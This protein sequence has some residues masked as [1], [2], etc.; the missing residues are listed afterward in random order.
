MDD[1][2]D[3]CLATT[4]GNDIRKGG[5]GAVGVF[6]EK[7]MGDGRKDEEGSGAVVCNQSCQREKQ[8]TGDVTSSISNSTLEKFM[9]L[10]VKLSSRSVLTPP[11]PPS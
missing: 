1:D 2:D 8:E 11:L 4:A 5:G 7:I 10:R 6:V 9:E 3:D